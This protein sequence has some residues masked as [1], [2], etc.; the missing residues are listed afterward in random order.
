MSDVLPTLEQLLADSPLLHDDGTGGTTS[1]QLSDEALRFIDS[2]IGS[3]S[4]TLETGEGLSTVLFALRGADHT[5]VSPN[6]GVIDRLRRFCSEKGIGLERVRF[7]IGF[8]QE[9]LPRLEQT[10]LDLV[11]IDG[12]HGFPIPFVD[13][14]YT[15]DRLRVG[16]YLIIDDTHIWTGDVLKRFIAAE[17]DWQL[18]ADLGQRSV[19]FTKAAESHGAKEWVDQPFVVRASEHGDWLGRLQRGA[20]MLARG[21]V[22]K[23]R[24][25]MKDYV[26]RRP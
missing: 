15:F 11:L 2:H 16:G 3:E 26:Y 19:V 24:D 12:G 6:T 4:R 8:S 18:L 25:R 10:P 5:C 9:V 17:T 20:A 21:D 1:W 13:W 22:R 7:E 23:F 14:L